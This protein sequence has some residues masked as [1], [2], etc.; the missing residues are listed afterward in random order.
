MQEFNHYLR[1]NTTYITGQAMS[2]TEPIH[3]QFIRVKGSAKM[4]MIHKPQTK[5]IL[6]SWESSANTN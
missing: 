5:K 1:H 3:G 2:Y 6:N 4:K